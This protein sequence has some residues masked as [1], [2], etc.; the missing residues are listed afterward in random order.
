MAMRNDLTDGLSENFIRIYQQGLPEAKSDPNMSTSTATHRS[1]K[2]LARWPQARVSIIAGAPIGSRPHGDTIPVTVTCWTK[3]PACPDTDA[4]QPNRKGWR[5]AL[6]TT[7]T[8]P[9]IPRD[10]PAAFDAGNTWRHRDVG[11]NTRSRR[12]APCGQPV[13]TFRPHDR[14]RA[15]PLD[16]GS[17]VNCRKRERHT[18]CCP[19]SRSFLPGVARRAPPKTKLL[20]RHIPTTRPYQQPQQ[21]VKLG[22]EISGDFYLHGPRL[23]K[24][25]RRYADRYPHRQIGA[26]LPRR[27]ATDHARRS[28]AGSPLGDVQ[29]PDDGLI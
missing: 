13:T 21:F 2:H 11:S 6:A 24:D 8:E 22:A 1:I 20:S 29:T 19:L 17:H 15:A 7:W 28:F 25:Q 18:G 9:F 10:L 23:A 14:R 26:G 5:I 12:Q 27:T 4:G 16:A 3:Y